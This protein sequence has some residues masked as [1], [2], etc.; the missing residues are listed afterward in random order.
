[1]TT[2]T[3]GEP[4]F[5]LGPALL[6]TPLP[7]SGGRLGLIAAVL[8]EVF[9]MRGDLREWTLEGE[10]VTATFLDWHGGISVKWCRARLPCELGQVR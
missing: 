6:A 4:D 5:R 3:H 2:S 10:E 8:Q 1:L 7:R 9:R